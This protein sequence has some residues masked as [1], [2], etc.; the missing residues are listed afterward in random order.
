[1][2]QYFKDI[3]Q[4][5][6]SV[7]PFKLYKSW[8]FDTSS[9]NICASPV[10][11]FYNGP[12]NYNINLYNSD[13]SGSQSGSVWYSVNQLY[14][15]LSES[16]SA[17][18]YDLLTSRSFSVSSSVVVVS[19]PRTKFGEGISEKS[20]QF[21]MTGAISIPYASAGNLSPDIL[22]HD[23]GYGNLYDGRN[24]IISNSIGNVV[25][26]H[27][28]I[29]FTDSQYYNY[30]YTA[31]FLSSS[32]IKSTLQYTSY[33]TAYEHEYIC[34]AKSYEFNVTSNPTVFYI[35]NDNKQHFKFENVLDSSGSQIV[36]RPFV[37]G[38]GLYDSSGNL[39]AAAKFA[40]PI[41]MEN[42]MDSVFIVRFDT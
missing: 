30:M 33:Y 3:S 28:L 6:Q 7:R 38:V 21:Y 17:A 32:L 2:P 16:G 40:K 5:L 8:T 37:T 9:Y 31:S 41:R 13:T 1:M 29:I 18:C 15:R 34:L 39:V 12:A 27:G 23:D 4:D 20:V 36:F 25:Y 26:P 11:N 14:Y 42:D 19:I 10:I 22:V 35:G 24:L